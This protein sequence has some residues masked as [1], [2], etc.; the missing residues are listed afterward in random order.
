MRPER[1]DLSCQ[2]YLGTPTADVQWYRN[3]KEINNLKYN[4][5]TGVNDVWRTLSIVKSE[6]TDSATYRCE[7]VNKV[8]KTQTECIVDV[9]RK[10]H[11]YRHNYLVIIF[12]ALLI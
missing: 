5:T 6:E 3:G 10:F 4:I 11:F 2:I 1:V 12:M 7:A 8:G 9:L